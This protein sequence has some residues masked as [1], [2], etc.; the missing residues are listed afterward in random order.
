[1]EEKESRKRLRN[2]LKNY[3]S[4][5]AQA[6]EIEGASARGEVLD[7]LRGMLNDAKDEFVSKCRI[8]RIILGYTKDGK[9]R[10]IMNMLY[11]DG[12]SM[13][14]IAKELK[15]SYGYCANIELKAIDRMS[16]D[17]SIMQLVG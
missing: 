13:E 11:V 14:Q 1:M 9:E 10:R 17:A 4:W 16:K 12:K 5:Q 8:V 7:S 15:Y 2:Y 3:R 6:K